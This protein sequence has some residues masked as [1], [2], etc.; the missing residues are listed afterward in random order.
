[1]GRILLRISFHTHGLRSREAAAREATGGAAVVR[2]G[3][4]RGRQLLAR[5]AQGG[6][7]CG[8]AAQVAPGRG[9]GGVLSVV[10]LRIGRDL[11]RLDSTFRDLSYVHASPIQKENGQWSREAQMILELHNRAA[12]YIG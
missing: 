12:G 2:T 6:Q 9:K 4:A 5:Q 11:K 8:S 1:M 3:C 7:G 10:L